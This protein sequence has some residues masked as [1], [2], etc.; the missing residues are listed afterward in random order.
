MGFLPKRTY[1]T[2]AVDSQGFGFNILVHRLTKANPTLATGFLLAVHEGAASRRRGHTHWKPELACQ[3]RDPFFE[4]VAADFHVHN[5]RCPFSD[6]KPFND[7]VRTLDER[8]WIGQPVCQDR[9]RG[10]RRPGHVSWRLN[11]DRQ[12]TLTRGPLHTGFTS[13]LRIL[14]FSPRK[15]ESINP[16]NRSL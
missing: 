2:A 1:H 14:I 12:R 4:T 15:V 5:N 6:G 10:H 11:I 13:P 3:R 9:Y 16:S 8:I 7:L